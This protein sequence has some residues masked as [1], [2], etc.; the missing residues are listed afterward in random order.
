L[1]KLQYI[2]TLFDKDNSKTI[3][4]DEMIELLRKLFIITG[5]DMKNDSSKSIALEIFR[6][7]DLDQNQSLSKEE[8]INGCLKNESIRNVL[9]PFENDYPPKS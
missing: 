6:I 2:Y 4:L 8:F 9:S 3:E 7:L 5:N 1:D